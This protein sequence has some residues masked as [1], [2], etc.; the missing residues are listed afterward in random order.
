MRAAWKYNH[1]GKPK[2][3]TAHVLRAMHYGASRFGAPPGDVPVGPPNK[4]QRT[5]QKVCIEVVIDAQGSGVTY[6]D[7][8]NGSYELKEGGQSFELELGDARADDAT[9][10][11]IRLAVLILK[12]R[13]LLHE[14]D[15]KSIRLRE[16][17]GQIAATYTGPEGTSSVNMNVFG[18]A[19]TGSSPAPGPAAATSNTM[20]AA[21]VFNTLLA[22]MP[23]FRRRAKPVEVTE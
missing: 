16:T 17:D 7:K 23:E 22:M 5:E 4:R 2:K 15:I 11:K 21:R 13:V 20:T 10:K 18:A 6:T 19:P 12:T 14:A 9:I 3:A 8:G 1:D